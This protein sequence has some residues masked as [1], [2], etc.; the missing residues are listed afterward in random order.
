MHQIPVPADVDVIGFAGIEEGRYSIPPFASV[1]PGIAAT[2]TS[3]L[4]LLAAPGALPG[5][6]REVPFRLL[7]RADP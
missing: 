7:R 2:A 4:D 1:D 3:I 5:V 6:H